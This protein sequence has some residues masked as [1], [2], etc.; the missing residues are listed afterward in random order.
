MAKANDDLRR[1]VIALEDEKQT[2]EGEK[3]EL[4]TKV[5]E[6]SRDRGAPLPQEVLAAIP[7][8]TLITVGQRGTWLEPSDPN[9][10]ATGVHVSVSAADG[11]GR[12]MQIVGTLRVEVMVFEP[13]VA[14]PDI[15]KPGA[16][17]SARRTLRA[18]LGPALLREAYREGLFGASYVVNLPLEPALA[19]RV[20]TLLVRAEFAD[21]ITGQTHEATT[22]IEA[23]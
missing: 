21:A 5:A 17:A 6:L 7:R 11:R 16:P 8:C 23:R 9:A 15:E 2:L 1:R 4:S 3:A 18:E 20:G 10:A 14:K 19:A 12:S 13:G 22:L